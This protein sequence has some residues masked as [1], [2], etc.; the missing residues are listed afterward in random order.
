MGKRTPDELDGSW[1]NPTQAKIRLTRAQNFDFSEISDQELWRPTRVHITCRL[2]YTWRV[3]TEVRGC[4][5]DLVE[6]DGS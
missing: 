3:E 1:R 5:M 6:A 2:N 4:P